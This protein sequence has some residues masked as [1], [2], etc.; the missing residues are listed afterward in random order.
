MNDCRA[1]CEIAPF[2]ILSYILK[3]L[4][5]SIMKKT[6]LYVVILLSGLFISSGE[7]SAVSIA[8]QD[9]ETEEIYIRDVKRLGGKGTGQTRSAEATVAAWYDPAGSMLELSFNE[10]VGNVTVYVLNGMNQCIASYNCNTTIETIVYMTVNMSEGDIY[11]IQ[12]VGSNYE[13]IGTLNLM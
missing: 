10:E 11:T 4:T 12:I 5:N 6:F 7:A 8:L 9:S 3:T 2:I 13:G 1:S